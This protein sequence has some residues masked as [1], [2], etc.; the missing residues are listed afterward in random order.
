MKMVAE[1]VGCRNA[2]M[3]ESDK[4]GG[5]ERRRWLHF[6]S[7]TV[8]IVPFASAHALSIVISLLCLAGLCTILFCIVVFGAK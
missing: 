5:G 2:A 1:T 6:S 4:V 7:A 3:G 8:M